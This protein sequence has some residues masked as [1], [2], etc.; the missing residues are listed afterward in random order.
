MSHT[1]LLLHKTDDPS[2]DSTN[3]ALYTKPSGTFTNTQTSMYAEIIGLASTTGYGGASLGNQTERYLLAWCGTGSSP[4]SN[5]GSSQLS[6]WSD[7]TNSLNDFLNTYASSSDNYVF[8]PNNETFSA[9]TSSL[10]DDG[11]Y[12]AEITAT[13]SGTPDNYYFIIIDKNNLGSGGGS[14]SSSSHSLTSWAYSSTS[15]TDP[16]IL[17]DWATSP[18]FEYS[19]ADTTDWK[20]DLKSKITSKSLNINDLVADYILETHNVERMSKKDTNYMNN[21]IE[22]INKKINTQ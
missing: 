9:L 20:A 1:K 3:W 10:V 17:I 12:F 7:G 8:N 19:T 5:V 18:Q 22:Y 2:V 6:H 21:F 13:I 16:N 15:A 14:S 11:Q 4:D